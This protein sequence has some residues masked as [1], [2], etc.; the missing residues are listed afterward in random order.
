[1]NLEEKVKKVEHIFDGVVVDLDVETVELPNGKTAKREIIRHQGAVAVIAIT[2]ENKMVFI[3]QWRAPLGQETLEVPAGKIEPNED[4]SITAMRELNEETRF[5]ADKMEFLNSFYTSP[6]FAD[7][8]MY[9]YHAI[10][11][12]PV[13]NKLPQDED[14]FLELVELSLPEVE[15]EISK[16]TICDSKTLISILY[17]K[18]MQ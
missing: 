14:E 4:P 6:G 13:T 17:W 2:P 1:M 8:K 18:M 3:R 9:L 7:E 16:G 11:L 12:K 15:V 10:N 5:E